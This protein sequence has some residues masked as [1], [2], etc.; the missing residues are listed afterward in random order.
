MGEASDDMIE[1]LCCMGCHL[2]F[3]REHGY[4]VYC[5]DCSDEIGLREGQITREGIQRA[6]NP[7]A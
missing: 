2:Y 6:I 7:E 4:P 3:E 5:R 1:G